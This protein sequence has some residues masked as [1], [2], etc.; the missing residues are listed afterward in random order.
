[1]KGSKAW[2]RGEIGRWLG[3]VVGMILIYKF[4]NKD[5]LIHVI[6]QSLPPQEAGLLTGIILGDKEGFEKTFYEKLKNSGLVHLVVVSG[7]NVM[8]LISGGIEIM[9]GVLGRKKAIGGG[10]IL[11]WGYAQMVGWEVPVVRAMLLVSLL[12]LAQLYGRKY[13]IWR[14]LLVAGGMMLVGEIRLVSSVSFWLSIAAFLGVITIDRFMNR[15]IKTLITPVWVSVWITPIL[16]MI[17]GKISL[18]SPIS[19][20]LV[21]GLVEIVTLVGVIGVGVGMVIPE[22]GKAVLWLTYPGLRYLSAVVE[23]GGKMPVLNIQFN[24]YLLI[25]WYLILGYWCW[26]RV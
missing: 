4:I 24:W 25:G 19:N 17:F 20:W 9:A 22:L 8:L 21:T 3:L 18:V 2:W 14:A 7:S 12:Y 13:D 11:G 23:W 1:M 26:R 6:R 10:L 15:T 16:A 5:D